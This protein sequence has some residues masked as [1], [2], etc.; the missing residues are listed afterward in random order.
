VA[1]LQNP[2]NIALV[3]KGGEIAVNR[4]GRAEGHRRTAS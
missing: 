3:I 1:L 2:E 4:L